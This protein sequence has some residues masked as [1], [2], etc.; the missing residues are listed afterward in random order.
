MITKLWPRIQGLLKKDHHDTELEQAA[1][2]IKIEACVLLYL[3]VSF[4][5][6]GSLRSEMDLILFMVGLLGIAVGVYKNILAKPGHVPFRRVFTSFMDNAAITYVLFNT[7][8]AILLFPIYLWVTLG[9]GFRF[10]LRY[11]FISQA[12]S[13]AGVLLLQEYSPHWS[14]TPVTSA[15]V[16][17]LI[18]IPLY[19]TSLIKR[20]SAAVDKAR[21]ASEAKSRFIS[22]VSH[23]IRTPLNGVIGISEILKL[24]RHSPAENAR[25]CENLSVSAHS[26]MR[27]LNDVLDMAKIESG[28]IEI[29]RTDFDLH[30][31]LHDLL[32]VFEFQANSKGIELRLQIAPDVPHCV[33]A[34]P[35]Q[36]QQILMNLIG[37]AVKFTDQGYIAVKVTCVSGAGMQNGLRFSVNDSG[38]GIPEANLSTVFE[39]FMQVE[40]IHNKDN[41]GTGLG[42]AI[43]KQLVEA[44]GGT[45]SVT[46]QE[47]VGTTFWFDLPIENAREKLAGDV[48][49][50]SLEQVLEASKEV[51][52]D[53]KILIAEDN[54]VNQMIV[55][56][57]L[58]LAGYAFT[59]T[60]DGEEA[61]DTLIAGEYDVAILDMLMPNLSGLDVCKAYK[62]CR[63]DDEAIEFVMFSA[64]TQAED[65]EKAKHIGFNACFPKP[66][67][68]TQLLK[69]LDSLATK[70]AHAGNSNHALPLS[71][72]AV[73]PS[74]S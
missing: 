63:M 74:L 38:I 44:M 22:N 59:M 2:R 62:F 34:A 32:H 42:M 53:L 71:R 26:L 73:T 10:G 29:K 55:A 28:K 45:I 69:Y 35:K 48:E 27:L 33:N 50:A 39:Q 11:L 36:I 52:K 70:K 54:P 43:A 20:L 13:I 46:S 47:G 4:L 16:A 3:L 41:V 25:L 30:T 1:V 19:A 15:F 58:N 51:R 40:N 72:T 18:L 12:F 24:N 60:S 57:V 56:D 65:I 67:D 21:E 17:T 14:H 23:E 5:Y 68:F 6:T 7:G 31:L 9:N 66:V 49:H 8:S 61:L 37:N 64:N